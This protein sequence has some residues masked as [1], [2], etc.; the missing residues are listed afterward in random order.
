M[1][2]NKAHFLLFYLTMT[3]AIASGL[4]I[5]SSASTITVLFRSAAEGLFVPLLLSLIAAFLLD[6]LVNSLEKRHIPRTR[7]IFSV[8]FMISATMLLLGSWLIPYGQNMWGSLLSD[9]PRYTSQLINYLREAQVSWQSRFPFL[10]QYDLTNTVRTTAE[11]VLSF[12]LVQTPKSALKLGSLMILLPIF[13]FFFLRDGTTIMRGMISLA[14]NRYFEMAHDLSFLVSRQMAH[15]VRGRVIEAA[16][17]GLVVALGLSL[18]DIRYA[19]LL[20]LFAG[21]TNLIPYIGPIVG[22]IPGILIA[23]VDLGLGGQFWWIVILYILIAQ[24]ILD[25]F[26]LIPVLISRVANLHPVL[27]ILA[28]VMGGK[29]YGVLGMIIGV[30]IAS[31]FKIAFTEIRHYR[32]AFAL[33]DTGNERHSSS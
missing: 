29:L 3:A 17:I 16:I 8:F 25:N 7:A 11:Q 22:M 30:P 21:V 9:F 23:A 2:L 27:V 26:I 31:A 14:P 15:F 4:A 6:P 12:V 1:N 33:P 18:T 5:F 10:A 24:V 32:R 13:S 19:P 20:G 28:I